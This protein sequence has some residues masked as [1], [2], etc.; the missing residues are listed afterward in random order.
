MRG[1]LVRT[2]DGTGKV[3]RFA[4]NSDTLVP[5]RPKSQAKE[6]QLRYGCLFDLDR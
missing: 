2:E 5:Q 3:D 1:E 6:Q 4:S